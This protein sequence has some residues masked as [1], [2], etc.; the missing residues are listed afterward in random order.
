VRALVLG[1]GAIGQRHVRNLRQ[2]LGDDVEFTAYRVRRNESILT[3]ALN[4]EAAR[5]LEEKYR[6]RAVPSLEAGLGEHPDFVLV[7]NPTSMHVPAATAAARAGCHLFIEKPLA[8]SW[9]GVENLI[10]AVDSH[11]NVALVAYQWRFHPLLAHVHRLLGE[12][13]LGRILTVRAE[14][15][16]YLPGWHPYED[17]RRMYAARRD[18]GGGVILSQIHEMDY[19]YWLFGQPSRVMAMGGQRSSLDIDVEDTASILIDFDGLPVHVQ[20]DY[21]QRPPRRSLHIVGESGT[22]LADLLAPRLQVYRDGQLIEDASF[23]GFTRA[24]MFLAEMQHF[25]RCV[26]GEDKPVVSLRD[27]SQSLAMALAAR[28][29]LERRQVVYLS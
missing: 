10:D 15:G 11:E 21:L 16:D 6:I 8:D 1:L 24:H 5:G 9:D 18:Q 19:L 28:E 3:D 13:M 20:L 23:A 4:V 7:C 25:L 17:Y 22:I 2:L 29:S 27:G 12:G 14:S 26:A